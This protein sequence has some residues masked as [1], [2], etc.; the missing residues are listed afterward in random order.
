MMK[1]PYPVNTII[2]VISK[3]LWL[4]VI[5]CACF[6]NSQAQF[7]IDSTLTAEELVMEHFLGKGVKIRNI[8]FT[9]SA[10]AI[11]K[12][13]N[14]SGKPNNYTD[15]ILLT[16]GKHR[17]ALGPNETNREVLFTIS[18]IVSTKSSSVKTP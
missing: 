18:S 10:D 7:S 4:L 5:F 3:R 2:N 12:F 16:T 15:G 11:A 14:P 17:G 8:T 9:G 13:A 1:R 6:L